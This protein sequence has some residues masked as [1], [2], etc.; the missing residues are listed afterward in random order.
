[1]MIKQ[2]KKMPLAAIAEKLRPQGSSS[3]QSDSFTE[4]ELIRNL[5][6][7]I[8]GFF[9]LRNIMMPELFP[10]SR[11]SEDAEALVRFMSKG[12]SNEK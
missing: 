12:L 3:P 2:I 6:T 5:L 1:M 10:K 4:A 11:L 9:I 8:S 7:C